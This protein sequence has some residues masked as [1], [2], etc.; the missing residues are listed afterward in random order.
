HETDTTLIDY[1]AD[2]RAPTPTAAAEAA[3]PVRTELIGY[4][5]DL[6]QRQRHGARRIASSHR[7]RLRA[8]RAGLPRPMDLVA[9]HRQRLDHAAS[10][11]F[12]CLRHSVQD[13]RLRFSRSGPRLSPHVLQQRVERSRLTFAPVAAGLVPAKRRH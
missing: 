2:L 7:D 11:L 9:T 6:G 1:A 10:N 5:E 13:R 12:S 8:A 3:V 4:V